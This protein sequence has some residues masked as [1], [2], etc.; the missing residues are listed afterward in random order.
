MTNDGDDLIEY[1]CPEKTHQTLSGLELQ[2]HERGASIL[3]TVL[4][5]RVCF[6][7]I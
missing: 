3:T 4:P 6:N 1:F 5:S 2:P 7:I